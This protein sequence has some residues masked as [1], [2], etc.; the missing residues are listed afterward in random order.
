MTIISIF[1]RGVAGIVA[2]TT[3]CAVPCLAQTEYFFGNPTADEQFYIE[4]INRARA[5]PPAEG[6]RLAATTDPNVLAAYAYFGVNL[7]LMQSEFNAIAAAPPL[8]PSQGLTVAARGHSQ[9]MLTHATQSH[10]QTNPSNDPG[11]RLT[12]AGYAWTTYGENIYAYSK[13]VWFGHAGFQVDWGTGGTGGMQSGRGHRA[14]IHNATFRE[15]GVGQVLGS[16]GTTNPVGPQLVTQDFGRQASN[17]PYYATGVAYYDLNGNNFYDPGE[18]ISG[19]RVDLS[20][21]GVSHFCTTAAGGG[22]AIPMSS[23]AMTRTVTFS[24]NGF[25]QPMSLVVSASK[26]AKADLELAYA[27][28]QIASA[29]TAYQNETYSLEFSGTPGASAY[30]WSRHQKQASPVENC[31]NSNA[32]NV[33]TKSGTYSIVQ[34]AVK[35]EGSSAFNLEN[36]TGHDQ[37]I[38]LKGLYHGG[39][40]PSLSYRS[41]IRYA[42]TAEYFR[43]LVRE[44]GT[45]NWIEVDTQ[46]GTNSSGQS[47]F[48]LRTVSLTSMSGKMFRV[49]FLL[50]STGS[51][52]TN[53][54]PEF[55][56][57]MD[58]IQF[59]NTSQLI[60]TV[61]GQTDATQVALSLAAGE[62]LLAVAPVVAGS[63]FPAGQ[64]SIQVLESPPPPPPPSY[65]TWAAAMETAAGL[66]AGAISNHPN[67]DHDGDG[68]ANLLEYAFGTS[69]V[70]ANEN[71]S[72]LPVNEITATHFIIRYQRDTA[73]GDIGIIAEAC[74]QL[75]S[76]KSPGSP[77][78]PAGF[79][80]ILISTAGNIQTREAR[81]P[82]QAN[83]SCFM[84][85]KVIRQ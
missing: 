19:L 7:T 15:I 63:I 78:A 43:V 77:G 2:V 69:P 53:T 66:V 71:S 11:Q 51:R 23:T 14:A 48:G 59:Q 21:S 47:A 30:Q 65:N 18:G 49:R 44:E 60:N 12:A 20:G 34:T 38:E 8:A 39:I 36:S 83:G 73:L 57:Y 50:N 79:E 37:C 1:Q 76:W 31:E 27:P 29:P 33:I 75:S 84:R 61:S 64:L 70:V 24:G 41:R 54:G 9:W 74:P 5:N 6:A 72:R 68:L 85:L 10:Y 62:Y 46:Q 45:P 22:W 4:L 55:G 82:L 3:F 16:N 35:Y 13:S 52:Y 58:A 42:T 40:S 56:W 81:Y 25:S 80:D 17:S 67:D 32:F 28:P 26:N